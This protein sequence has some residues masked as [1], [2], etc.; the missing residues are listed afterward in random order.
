MYDFELSNLWIDA[1][2][3]SVE[4][5]RL[6]FCDWIM[7]DLDE[8][9]L[10]KRRGISLSSYGLYLLVLMPVTISSSV[11]SSRLLSEYLRKF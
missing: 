10:R 11:F 3:R 6:A 9:N 2:E 7:V 1:F 4:P 5:L 8:S